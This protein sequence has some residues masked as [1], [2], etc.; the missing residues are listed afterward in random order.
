MASNLS[1]LA[2][3][4]LVLALAACTRSVALTDVADGGQVFIGRTLEARLSGRPDVARLR[5]T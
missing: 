5:G 2:P 3:I 4:G 1:L